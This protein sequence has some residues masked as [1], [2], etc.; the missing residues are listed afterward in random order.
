M[1]GFFSALHIFFLLGLLATSAFLSGSETSLFSL[2]SVRLRRLLDEKKRGAST[3]AEVLKE[4]RNLLATILLSN[5]FV[6]VF[7]TTLAEGMAS[8]LLGS[9]GLEISITVMSIVILI[10]CE[11]IPKILAVSKA[12]QVSLWV[13]PILKIFMAAITP[14]RR[15]FMGIANRIMD[16]WIPS[17]RHQVKE[18]LSTEQLLT[19]VQMG[20][21]DGI[22]SEDEAAMLHGILDLRHKKVS[23]VMTP[24]RDVFG[25]DVATPLAAIYEEIRKQKYS[26]VVIYENNMD[27]VLGILYAKDLLMQEIFEMKAIQIF[28]LLRKPFFVGQ[29]QFLDQLLKEF[30]SRRL[31]L[32][33][34]N[35][36]NHKWVG[37][38]TLDDIFE[39]AIDPSLNT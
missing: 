12:E 37:L 16:K 6:T 19:A 17:H 27:R 22:L 25:F 2:S 29:D 35:D 26:R 20:R 21:D 15:F 24:R 8:D 4:P 14:L 38:V 23:D 3:V 31:H 9:R 28:D 1:N 10:F 39:V 32:A 30:R 34:V 5:L 13:S 18:P 33:L 36:V 7:A 11:I